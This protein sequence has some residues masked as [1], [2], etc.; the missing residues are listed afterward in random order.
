MNQRAA[1][2]RYY[3]VWPRGSSSSLAPGEQHSC[4]SVA[5]RRCGW[6]SGLP[7][8]GGCDTP[9]NPP[10]DDVLFSSMIVDWLQGNLCVDSLRIFMAGFS[11]G[12]QMVYKLNCLQAER[13]AGMMTL[14]AA[15][16]AAATPGELTC[17]P[18][19][20]LPI[21]NFCSSSDNCWGDGGSTVRQQLEN[22]AIANDC[23]ADGAVPATEEQTLSEVAWCQI[24]T[25]CQPSSPVQGCGVEGLGHCWPQAG[26]GAG[27]PEC[28]GQDPRNPDVS[29]YVLKFFSQVP[30]GRPI[31]AI[32]GWVTL[33]AV[34]G[35]GV[36]TAFAYFGL[37]G[38]RNRYR[39]Q[40]H[41]SPAR[42]DY[43]PIAAVDV[44]SVI[45]RRGSLHGTGA[46]IGD[47][48]AR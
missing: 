24:A 14:G 15:A 21:V 16:S 46:D 17:S 41:R 1:D 33:A 35:G 23:A 36:A 43:T 4:T 3:A 18:A 12:A 8:P 44:S 31:G 19:K 26:G 42:D 22:F 5:G 40:A 37:P 11:N 27:N 9:T 34:A 38:L 45:A 47:S 30:V 29:A 28:L 2:A 32:V 20:R 10:P 25:G 7:A 13:F 39:R 48:S 6:N